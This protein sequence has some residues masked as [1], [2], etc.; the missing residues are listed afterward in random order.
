MDPVLI[1][2]VVIR[3]LLGNHNRRSFF[4]REHIQAGMEWLSTAQDI[5][6]NGGVSLRY[7]L[8]YG[9]APSYPET[10]GYIIT[11]FL[12]YYRATSLEEY[13][14]RAVRMADWELSIQNGDGSFNGGP[15]G[16][17]L[18][19][20][21]FDT[22]QVI[23]GL[24]DAYKF[25]KDENYLTSAVKAA[26]WLCRTQESDGSWKKNA[27][28]GIPHTYYSRVAW[29]LAE[30]GNALDDKRYKTAA[31]K[32][33]EWALRNQ[34]DNGWFDNAA[35]TVKNRAYPYTHTIA[36]TIRGILETGYC[37]KE[38]KYIYAAIKS[39]DSLLNIM[40][41]SGFFWGTYSD[42]W[43]RGN[44]SSCLTGNAQISII[45]LRLFEMMGESKYLKAAKLL[46]RYLMTR[47]DIKIKDK[48]I[49]GAIAGSYPI[50]GR[51]QKFAF[52]NWA[53]K[54]FIDAL[55]LEEELSKK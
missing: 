24:L 41:S 29:A 43:N 17:G 51:Y 8:I 16:S 19:G 21:A 2:S 9:W 15:L 12:N 14:L 36:Y 34:H 26:D 32:N 11:T 38:D 40:E 22:G 4:I 35:F 44:S 48:R 52:P 46:N 6:G 30:I 31:R 13:K 28:N 55:M 45:F 23:F 20:F 37:L 50:W 1:S 33:I 10:T 27:Y 42:D 49:R 5:A 7:S 18:G 54:F 25:T 47:Q 39:A 3:D 53:T